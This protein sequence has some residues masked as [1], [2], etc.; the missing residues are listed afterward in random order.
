MP[1]YEVPIPT[2]VTPTDDTAQ[3]V[4]EWLTGRGV[5]VN[6]VSIRPEDGV[7]V[8]DADR[9][10]SA[11]LAAYDGTASAETRRIRQLAQT[12]NAF[13][14][15]VEAG[16]TPTAAQRDQALRAVIRLLQTAYRAMSE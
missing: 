2:N 9:D 8:V 15:A 4:T 5:V 11:D 13:A 16:Q 14:A 3:A 7:V 1:R 12:A 10:P 6:G